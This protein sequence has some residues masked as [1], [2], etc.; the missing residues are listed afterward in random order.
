MN[1]SKQGREFMRHGASMNIDHLCMHQCYRQCTDDAVWLS[2]CQYPDLATQFA[3]RLVC[4]A[5]GG[6]PWSEWQS[7]GDRGPAASAGPTLPFTLDLA[8][9][10]QRKAVSSRLQ[11][12]AANASF[13]VLLLL[14]AVNA[15]SQ[16]LDRFSSHICSAS[17]VCAACG[18]VV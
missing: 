4:R 13:R 6:G 14:Q 18:F 10:I 9:S 8:N 17:R 16:V 3:K 2:G 12:W 11:R 5:E 7:T 1:Q 15:V